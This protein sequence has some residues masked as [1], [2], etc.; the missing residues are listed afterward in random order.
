MPASFKDEFPSLEGQGLYAAETEGNGNCL[1]HALSDQIYGNQAQHRDIRSRVI[2]YMREHATYYKQFIDVNAGR[3]RNPKRKNAGAFATPIIIPTAEE[4]DRVFEHHLQ[5]MAKGGTYGDNLEISAFS[6]AYE[7]DVSIQQRDNILYVSTARPGEVRRVAYV[8]YHIFEHY[9]SIRNV[10]GPHNGPPNVQPQDLTDG[11]QAQLNA[12]LSQ[13]PVAAPWMIEVVMKSVPHI[14]DRLMIKRA[15]EENK[16]NINDAV[17]MLLDMDYHS[18][19]STQPSSVER[20]LD[21][22]DEASVGGPTKKQDRRLSRATRKMMER[23]AAPRHLNG[24]DDDPTSSNDGNEIKGEASDVDSLALP[25]LKSTANLSGTQ[26]SD[27]GSEF[28]TTSKISDA[29]SLAPTRRLSPLQPKSSRKGATGQ[30]QTAG[31]EVKRITARERKDAKKT[32]QKTAA[33]ARKQS[34]ALSAKTANMAPS[35]VLPTAKIRDSGKEHQAP[36]MQTIRTLY[37]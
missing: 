29:P 24:I 33:K 35:N 11:A 6:E 18:Q 30:Q 23:K 19:S 5:R 17:D 12:K 36:M 32:A 26:S 3:R 16:G 31:V 27:A 7:V 20:D 10:K 25:A 13:R 15:L 28:S 14:A 2:E 22:D 9:S 4:I 34:K 21:S 8:A 1:F 37:I